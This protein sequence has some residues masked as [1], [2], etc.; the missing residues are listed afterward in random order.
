MTTTCHSSNI[1]EQ[2]HGHSALCSRSWQ[3]LCP[4][5]A[6]TGFFAGGVKLWLGVKPAAGENFF[7]SCMLLYTSFSA[8]LG[9]LKLIL[10]QCFLSWHFSF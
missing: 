9:E 7:K 3:Q 6:P 10:Y 4:A 8:F 5:W 1:S 2:L